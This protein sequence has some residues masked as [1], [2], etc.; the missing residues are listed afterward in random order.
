MDA[1]FRGEDWGLGPVPEDYRSFQRKVLI[2]TA[3]VPGVGPDDAGLARSFERA[4]A[5]VRIWGPQAGARMR[6]LGSTASV[7]VGETATLRV[8]VGGILPVS[9]PVR[10][11]W[12][13]DSPERAGFAYETLPGHPEDGRE[14]FVVTRG[15]GAEGFEEAWFTVSAYSK[16]ASV[17][18][19]LG[20][21]VTRMIQ[22]RYANKY[23]LA[24]AK[25][26]RTR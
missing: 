16:P 19:R 17:L 12:T 5:L 14:S 21:P 24:I 11:C 10:I 15:V 18:A 20:G 13:V 22:H 23:L 7:A 3:L 8:R 4:R 9:A 6:L 26:A 25:A 2:S 1:G